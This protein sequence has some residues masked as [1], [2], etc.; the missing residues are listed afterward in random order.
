MATQLATHYYQHLDAGVQQAEMRALDSLLGADK[1]KQSKDSFS[2]TFFSLFPDALTEQTKIPDKQA[3]TIPP[4]NLLQ[5][6]YP[7]GQS[8]QTWGGTHSFSGQNSGPRSSLDFRQNRSGFGSNTT[9]LWVS[10]SS[11]GSAVKHS[12]C[13][14]EVLATGGWSTTYYHLDRIQVNTGQRISRNTRLANY[15]DNLTQSLCDGGMSNGPHVH[16]SLK[17]N[18][19]YVSLDKV[20]LSGYEIQDGRRD[21]DTDCR[22]FWLD[23]NGTKFCSGTPIP[24]R[25]IV[26]Q[27][28]PSPDLL[29]SA[30][31]TDKP[32]LSINEPLSASAKLQN[33]GDADSAAS[34][35]TFLLSN[36]ALITPSDIKLTELATAPLQAGADIN[37]SANAIK[38]LTPGSFWIGACAAIVS[39]E[40][41]TAN[42]CSSGVPILVNE[43]KPTVVPSIFLLLLDRNHPE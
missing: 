14:A 13:F 23:D 38:I 24:N 42:N 35:L 5:L 34:Q 11:S 7:I 3:K 27:P 22:F 4:Q 25:G 33:S 31:V 26:S 37:Y 29:V 15:A 10:S 9:N 8:W 36:D 21:Y 40:S 20:T 16:F 28:T 6:P 2:Q 19:V 39:G 17:R 30:L 18:G 43:N 41:N 1:A 12:S 32:A